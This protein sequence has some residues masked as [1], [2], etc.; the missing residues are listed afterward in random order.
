MVGIRVRRIPLYLSPL[1]AH[2]V[3]V[4][5]D[6]LTNS[7]GEQ[8]SID[9]FGGKRLAKEARRALSKVRELRQKQRIALAMNQ[10]SG[11]SP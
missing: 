8:E 3:S 9:A 7:A 5:L 6:N 10:D 11:S 1:Q 4:A 2:A